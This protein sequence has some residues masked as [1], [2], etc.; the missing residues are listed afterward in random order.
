MRVI[1]DKINTDYE[2]AQAR[3]RARGNEGGTA[4]VY[5][6]F[7]Q[8]TEF[9]MIGAESKEWSLSNFETHST[10]RGILAI[11]QQATQTRL[12]FLNEYMRVQSSS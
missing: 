12:Q 1:G 2:W 4:D 7:S 8:D 6:K 3:I 9:I 11:Q 10:E 5:T